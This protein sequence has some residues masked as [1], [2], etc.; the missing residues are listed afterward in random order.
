MYKCS[1]WKHSAYHK[2][3]ACLKAHR[4]ALLISLEVQ[5]KWTISA[6]CIESATAVRGDTLMGRGDTACVSLTVPQWS[7][8]TLT[9]T[10]SGQKVKICL[11]PH[12]HRAHLVHQLSTMPRDL[13]SSQA[14]CHMRGSTMQKDLHRLC[15]ELSSSWHA[16]CEPLSHTAGE[17]ALHTIYL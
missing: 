6:A 1:H 2:H 12:R 17:F 9:P 7:L 16:K 10:K 15:K 3:R 5:Q 8:L 14:T 11:Q 13:S 4:K